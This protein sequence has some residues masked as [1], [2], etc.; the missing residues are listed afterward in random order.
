MNIEI[1]KKAIETYGE[2]AQIRQCMEE[3]AELISAIVDYLENYEL[4][5]IIDYSES[6]ELIINS[7]I[8]E[9]AD[10]LITCKQVEIISNEHVLDPGEIEN[11][12]IE[13]N[14]IC[15]ITI[16]QLA[17]LIKTLNKY[18][19]EKNVA[20]YGIRYQISYQIS[21][22]ILQFDIF[23]NLLE[24]NGVIDFEKQINKQ[25]EYKLNRLKERLNINE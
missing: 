20:N 11:M 15:N 18:L 24:R 9:M 3:C 19:R 21:C 8:E 23:S 14:V 22:L 1:L 17:E 6:N 10:V 2:E 12:D 13:K 7:I 4:N 5:A 25:I 16:K